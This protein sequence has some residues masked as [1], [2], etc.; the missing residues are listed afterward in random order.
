MQ[1]L[2]LI[3]VFVISFQTLQAQNG[4]INPFKI[5]NYYEYLYK[6]S[7]FLEYRFK[8]KITK[9]TIINGKKFY[10][11]N[12]YDEPGMGNYSV[13][14]RLDTTTL[15]IYGP[16][17]LCPDSTGFNLLG[18]FRLPVGYT[19]D[20][21]RPGYFRSKIADTATD[22][23]IFNTGI[24]LKVFSRLDTMAGAVDGIYKTYFTEMFGYFYFFSDHGGIFEGQGYQKFLK[25][26]VING[27]TYGEIL[28][29]INQISNEIPS[30]YELKQNYPNP[31]NP[32]TVI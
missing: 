5:G 10:T 31:F 26:A 11:M 18:G 16:G 14:F 24:P 8:A 28:S 7:E 9:D 21:C 3:L 19:W 17:G 1:K 2:I 4:F 12:F 32:S 23:D 22:Y 6:E 15:N 20:S 29:D 13:N 30:G 27:V 25:G